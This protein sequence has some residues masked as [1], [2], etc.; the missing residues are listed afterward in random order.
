V[1]QRGRHGAVHA[2]AE[3]ADD[4]VARPHLARSGRTRS[5]HSAGQRLDPCQARCC[6]STLMHTS[7]LTDTCSCYAMGRCM[8]A[9]IRQ[10][11]ACM[12]SHS[13]KLAAKS[14]IRQVFTPSPGSWPSPPPVHFLCASRPGSARC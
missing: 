10:E 5:H 2:A 11:M 14:L 6:K 4:V 8:L 7:L 3:R 9:Q 12:E 1:H 13:T